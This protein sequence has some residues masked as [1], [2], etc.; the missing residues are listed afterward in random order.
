[1]FY[2]FSFDCSYDAFLAKSLYNTYRMSRK[3]FTLARFKELLREDFDLDFNV[4]ECSEKDISY[5]FSDN[6]F[7]VF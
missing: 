1:M 2:V 7:L 3:G 6:S 5:F 4:F